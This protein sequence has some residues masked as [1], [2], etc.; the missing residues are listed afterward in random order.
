MT[1]VYD[2]RLW[3]MFE[4]YFTGGQQ[5]FPM[6]R[7]PPHV[8]YSVAVLKEGS[9]PP[10]RANPNRLDLFWLCRTLAWEDPRVR[11]CHYSKLPDTHCGAY[12]PGSIVHERAMLV[13]TLLLSSKRHT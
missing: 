8:G 10:N 9:S 4:A 6:V 12:A 13:A 7:A 3:H 5:D 2:L 11:V 1:C